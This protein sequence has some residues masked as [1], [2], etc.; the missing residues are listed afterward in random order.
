M[1]TSLTS[2]PHYTTDSP[3][4]IQHYHLPADEE[5]HCDEQALQIVF[6][7]SCKS[8]L[9][10][11]YIPSP[12]SAAR[13]FVSH[14]KP[15]LAMSWGPVASQPRKPKRQTTTL[16]INCQFIHKLSSSY[17]WQ[18]WCKRGERTLALP[19]WNSLY[20]HRNSRKSR[21]HLPCVPTSTIGI[22]LVLR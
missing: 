5:N 13:T 11:S 6:K 22:S 8:S 18:C 21:P 15:V 17:T 12:E 20:S 1:E 10:K 9:L 7:Y 16:L 4:Q 19:A 2:K 3:A 14:L